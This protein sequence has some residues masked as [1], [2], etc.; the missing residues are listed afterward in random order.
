MTKYK[1]NYNFFGGSTQV[2]LDNTEQ[3]VVTNVATVY[4]IENMPQLCFGLVNHS[5]NNEILQENINKAFNK[6]YRHFDGA[7]HYGNDLYKEAVKIALSDKERKNYWLTWKDNNISVSKVRQTIEKLNCEY[8]DLFLVHLSCGIENDYIALEDCKKLGLI[9]YWGVSNCEN[10]DSIRMLKDRFNIYANQIQARPPGG[11]VE[12]RTL[13]NENFVNE[14]NE[15]GVKIMLFGTTSG[16][17]NGLELEDNIHLFEYFWE[18]IKLINRYYKQKYITTENG[19]VLM[20][21][22]FN[23]NS[24]NPNYD[25]FY[26]NILLPENKMNEMNSKLIDF[27][28]SRQ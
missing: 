22:S 13:L 25:E 9:R 18:N 20:T 15:I 5:N 23:G 16:V 11:K 12:G 8:I 2:P 7:E 4:N 24:I 1:I 3:V 27:T 19:N 6:G 28:L 14:C 10:I 17:S 26:N 21:S